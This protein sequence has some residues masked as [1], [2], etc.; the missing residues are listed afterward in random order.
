[1]TELNEIM[2]QLRLSA[3]PINIEGM[4]RFGI[5]GEK[6]LGIKMTELEGFRKAIGKNHELALLL[7]NEGYHE[8]RLLAA[9]IA[10]HKKVT[11]ELMDSWAN[12]F[13]NWAVYD[14]VCGKLFRKSP[15][16]FDKI[17]QWQYSDKLW[18]KR[19]SFTLIAFV[20]VHYKNLPDSFFNDYHIYFI[21]N[22]SDERNY[23]KKAVNW[24]IRQIGKRNINLAIE[25]CNLCDII[26]ETYPD[27]KSAK[28]IVSDAKR[29]LKTKFNI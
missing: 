27:S 9:M 17:D 1:M 21:N 23:I 11:P 18:V 22:A 16:T 6:I 28:W 25:M 13:D 20:A 29:E 26:K 15:F 2:S 19:A 3:N 12:D 4:A 10:D 5:T 7:W 14:S 24:A 8:S